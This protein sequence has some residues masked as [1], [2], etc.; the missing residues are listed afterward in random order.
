MQTDICCYPSTSMSY[1][2]IVLFF[3]FAAACLRLTAAEKP[4]SLLSLLPGAPRDSACMDKLNHI[5]KIYYNQ[6]NY[7]KAIEYAKQGLALADSLH[8]NYGKAVSLNRLG[9][10]YA[11]KGELTTAL[12]YFF[13]SLKIREATGDQKGMSFAYNNIGNI[14][15]SLD[16]VDYAL[17]YM[18]KSLAIK[19]QLKD[20]TGISNSYMNIGN[21]YTRIRDSKNALIRYQKALEIRERMHMK[22]GM[23]ALLQNMAE[24]YSHDSL[25]LQKALDTYARSYALAEK[26]GEKNIMA[27]VLN[28]T[29]V[30]YIRQNTPDKALANLNKS[31]EL[32]KEIGALDQVRDAYQ[33]FAY[34]YE[35]KGDYKSAFNYFTR[36]ATVKDTL[37]NAESNKQFA[38]MTGRYEM[39]KKDKAISLLK[40]EGQI[41]DLTISRQGIMRN[42]L[43]VLLGL[44][45]ITAFLLLNRFQVKKKANMLLHEQNTLIENK[46]LELEKLSIVASETINGV[47]IAGADGEIEW[48]NQGFTKLLGYEIDEFKRLKGTNILKASANPEI[49]RLIAK[50]IQDKKSVSYEAINVNRAGKEI[51]LQSTLT[52]ILN[53]DGELR[54][55]VVIDS[56]ITELKKAEGVI[57][58]KNRS[59][60]DSIEYARRIQQAM[61]PAP[62]E[63]QKFLGEHSLMYLPKD[64]VSGDF[65]WLYGEEKGQHK[66][67]VFAVAD[68]T[69]HGVPGALMSMIGADQLNRIVRE[70]KQ[71]SPAAVLIELNRSIKKAM[72]KTDPESK[73]GMEIGICRIDTEKQELCFAGANRPLFFFRK[74]NNEYLIEPVPYDRAALGGDTP[75]DHPFAEHTFHYSKGD[76]IYLTSDGFSDQFGGNPRRKYTLAALK[77]LLLGIQHKTMSQQSIELSE[78]YSQWKG[79]QAQTDDVTLVGISLNNI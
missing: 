7:D 8:N 66:R 36:Y 14:Y 39:E 32:A 25:T 20:S 52:P 43:F 15:L 55:L 2:H 69:G 67:F 54:K 4:D 42:L 23:A 64:I 34:A 17:L 53:K 77:D 24:L 57:R 50:S 58:R 3:A 21:V 19:K 71:F 18:E 70:E 75:F 27:T 59:I 6:S 61:L 60:T 12:S 65:F 79:S 73:D 31:L 40:K 35:K 76:V 72:Q 38:E 10:V 11:E 45:L 5:S 28:N 37:L 30:I 47:L 41:R 48:A 46:N 9:S 68:C 63:L 1:K 49:D 74:T 51:W 22:T 26:S 33:S 56:D 78:T 62:E 44:S 29:A 13:Q 16:K